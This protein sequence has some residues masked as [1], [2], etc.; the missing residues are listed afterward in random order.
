MNRIAMIASV[1]G[2]SLTSFASAA[3]YNFS[4]LLGGP[5]Q[6]TNLGPSQ[7]FT[8][9]SVT[10][11][12][13]GFYTNNTSSS[14]SSISASATTDTGVAGQR[15]IFDKFTSG[16]PAETGIGFAIA[17]VNHEVNNLGYLL[18]NVSQIAV[19]T[20]VTVD[21]SSIQSGEM[22]DVYQGSSSITGPLNLVSTPSM[23]S[24]SATYSFTRT[25]TTQYV[26]FTAPTGD[27]LINS[28]TFASTPEPR[29]YGIL[30]MGL[31][32]L[33]GIISRKRRMAQ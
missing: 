33:A 15:D 6:N 27:V 17:E 30:L 14:P 11:T 5:A 24:N 1:V 32:G 28:L 3:T 26:A 23:P 19:G 7:A 21:V 2:L 20:I 12:A 9:G 18:L 8:Q 16:D 25:G 13:Y 31:L 22:Y 29:F 4:T 10:I